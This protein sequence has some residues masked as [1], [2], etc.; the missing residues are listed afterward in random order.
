MVR[1]F[2]GR[3]IRRLIAGYTFN[4]YKEIFDRSGYAILLIDSRTNRFI[5]VNK[6]AC[7]LFGYTQAE[8]RQLMPQALSVQ[9]EDSATSFEERV[10]VS[11]VKPARRKDG[12]I[13]TVNVQTSISDKFHVSL[14]SDVT[15]EYRIR[16]ALELNEERLKEAQRIGRFG[17][18]EFLPETGNYIGSEEISRIFNDEVSALSFTYQDNINY[19]HPEDRSYLRS[20]IEEAIEK[21]R[22]PT[23]FII[24]LLRRKAKSRL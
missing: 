21:K 7:D 6:A 16:R 12:T 24:G 3:F 4:K 9:P 19:A 5:R 1:L 23:R 8:M 11:S 14:V 20:S 17:W 15:E 22:N 10:N 13:I 2:P 18:W